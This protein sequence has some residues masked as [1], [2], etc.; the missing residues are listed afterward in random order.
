VA[1]AP[2]FSVSAVNLQCELTNVSTKPVTVLSANVLD[3]SGSDITNFNNCVGT[4][5]PGVVCVFNCQTG[6]TNQNPH[7]I[8]MLKG[9]RK[10]VRGQ[11]ALFDGSTQT[12]STPIES[13]AC[14]SPTSTSRPVRG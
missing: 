3:A 5:P 6:A 9:S 12:V 11:C 1:S 7:A 13:A 10:A 8:V 14:G 2:L 4:L